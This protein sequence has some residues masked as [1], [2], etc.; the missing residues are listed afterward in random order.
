MPET[1]AASS[2]HV[3]EHIPSP[4]QNGARSCENQE[5]DLCRMTLVNRTTKLREHEGSITDPTTQSDEQVR[6]IDDSQTGRGYKVW[7]CRRRPL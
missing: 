7:W 6:T 2:A 5:I 4:K 3:A 1:G